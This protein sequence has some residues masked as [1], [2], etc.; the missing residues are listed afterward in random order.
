MKKILL[1]STALVLSAVAANAQAFNVT[2]EGRMGL[3]YDDGA[4]VSPITGVSGNN[5]SNYRVENRLTLNFN[6]A[7]EADHGLSFGAFTRARMQMGAGTA[8]TFGTNGTGVFSGSRVWVEANGLRLTFGNQDGAIQSAGVA[9]GYFGGCGVGYEGGQQCGDSAGLLAVSQMFNSTGA[10]GGQRVQL[11]YTMGD[12]R[13]ALS[14]DRGGATEIGIRGTFDAFTVALG[15]SNN[16]GSAPWVAI[17]APAGTYAPIAA[18]AG[19]RPTGTLALSGRYNGGSWTVGAIIARVSTD[20]A[21]PNDSFT[22]YA[23]SGSAALGG[24]NLYGY[25]GRTWDM[26]SY[27][28]NYGYGLGGGAT[29]TVGAERV[30]THTTASVGVAFTF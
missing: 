26:S 3:Q 9:M 8:T 19:F 13:F 27:G 18:L 30:G 6:V 10:A 29:M 11:T 17:P 23:I 22:N 4:F 12:I 20:A 16:N 21:A 28:L 25:V 1:A 15:W 14:N 2:G 7:V 24:G 5:G